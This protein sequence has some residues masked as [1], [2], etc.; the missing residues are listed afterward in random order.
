MCIMSDERLDERQKL[1][2]LRRILVWE[3]S[4]EENEVQEILEDGGNNPSSFFK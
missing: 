1:Y 4:L 3:K 2:Q